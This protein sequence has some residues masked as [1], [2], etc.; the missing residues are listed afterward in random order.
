M[1]SFHSTAE[2]IVLMAQVSETGKRLYRWE[3][4]NLSCEQLFVCFSKLTKSPLKTL[5]VLNKWLN[6]LLR[7]NVTGSCSLPLQCRDALI[8][9]EG[10]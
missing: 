10:T 4:K 7:H 8:Q 3:V 1:F 2:N 9:A 5:L 6:F